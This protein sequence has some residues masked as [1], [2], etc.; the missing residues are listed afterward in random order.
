MEIVLS[1]YPDLVED[2]IAFLEPEEA[3]E[4][5]VVSIPYTAL[6]IIRKLPHRSLLFLYSAWFAVL[7]SNH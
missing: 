4:A 6:N 1:E 5:G 7:F 2:F 3:L